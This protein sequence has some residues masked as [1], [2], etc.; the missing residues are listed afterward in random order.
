[1]L[2]AGMLRHMDLH[3]D[4]PVICSPYG[5]A[6]SHCRTNRKRRRQRIGS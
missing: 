3:G 1:V 4:L 2:T 6:S 5:I